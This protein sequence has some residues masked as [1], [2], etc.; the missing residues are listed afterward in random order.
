MIFY[1]NSRG[2]VCP[3]RPTPPTEFRLLPVPSR[4]PFCLQRSVD[5]EHGEFSPNLL[6]THTHTH[7][8]HFYQM[9]LSEAEPPTSPTPPPPPRRNTLRSPL[10]L[11][12]CSRSNMRLS[13]LPGAQV[14]FSSVQRKFKPNVI[15]CEQKNS[16]DA[17]NK[18]V[19]AALTELEAR[20]RETTWRFDISCVDVRSEPS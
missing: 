19:T 16:S 11:T 4:P 9:R 10:F 13:S 6:H 2:S 12:S 17:R 5:L 1:T 3:R 7:I 8:C 18:N 20:F 15:R 14:L